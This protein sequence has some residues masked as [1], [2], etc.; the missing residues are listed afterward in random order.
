[1]KKGNEGESLEAPIV[2]GASGPGKSAIDAKAGTPEGVRFT[3]AEIETI[4]REMV[5]GASV[6]WNVLPDT[7]EP[8]SAT[9]FP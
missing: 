3:R 7:F 1:M 4:L 2:R 6:E 5:G 8:T 9:V